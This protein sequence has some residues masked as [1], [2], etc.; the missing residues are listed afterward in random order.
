MPSETDYPEGQA[1]P[2]EIR[3]TSTHNPDYGKLRNQ[4]ELADVVT[5]LTIIASIVGF[6][7]SGLSLQP[8]NTGIMG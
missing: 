3:I 1:Q 4:Q 5:E 8:Q 7:L 6:I 2:I